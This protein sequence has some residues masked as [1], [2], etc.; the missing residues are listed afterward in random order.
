MNNHPVV[1]RTGN[2]LR[3][4]AVCLTGLLLVGYLVAV[5]FGLLRDSDRLSAQDVVLAL[6]LFVLLLFAAQSTYSLDSFSLGSS[7][8]T[9]KV[10]RMAVRQSELESEIRALQIAVGGI[11]S[12]YEI[13]HL[14]GLAGDGP[15]VVRFGEIFVDEL[16]HLD[17]MG[18]VVPR[19][20]RGLNAIRDDHGSGEDD[21]DLKTYVDIT[22][23]GREYLAL[24]AH[25]ATRTANERVAG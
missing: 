9:A 14:E 17:G 6:V 13:L 18:F 15:A 23:E 12:K 5:P 2:R 24:R 16:T 21:F 7:G 20:V 19:D 10:E 1:R 11:V 4:L 22:M 25:L 3:W 8:L